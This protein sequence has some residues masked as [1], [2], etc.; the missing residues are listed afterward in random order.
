MAD[1]NLGTF[2]AQ[3]GSNEILKELKNIGDLNVH[4]HLHVVYFNKPYK[5]LNTSITFQQIE[6]RLN[7]FR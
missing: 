7:R 4:I 3:G 6:Q 1:E 5:K 2:N